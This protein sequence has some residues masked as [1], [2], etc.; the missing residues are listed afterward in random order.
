MKFKEDLMEILSDHR[1][2]VI[3]IMDEANDPSLTLEVES[4]FDSMEAE[5]EALL[6]SSCD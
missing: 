3:E 2:N 6:G 1:A 5:V 4:K